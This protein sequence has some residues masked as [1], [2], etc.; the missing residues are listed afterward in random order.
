MVEQYNM[1]A[2][3]HGYDSSAMHAVHGDFVDARTNPSVDLN[4][5]EFSDFDLIAMSMALHH[6]EDPK[7]L[8]KTLSRRLRGGGV[9]LIIDWVSASE[10]G[11]SS[12][13]PPAGEPVSHTVACMGFERRQLD[14]WFANAGLKTFGWKWFSSQSE[15]PG[16]MGGLKQGFLARAMKA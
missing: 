4:G 12:A 3:K 15:L 2:K 5:P 11:C 6:V 1:L 10:S 14:D 7:T 9:L 8:I 16:E 13:G